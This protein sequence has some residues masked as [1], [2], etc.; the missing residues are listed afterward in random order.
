MSRTTRTRQIAVAV[1]DGTGMMPQQ[2]ELKVAAAALGTAL[3]V[4]AV[5]LLRVAIPVVDAWPRHH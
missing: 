2:V 3:G 4:A 5:G 1:S